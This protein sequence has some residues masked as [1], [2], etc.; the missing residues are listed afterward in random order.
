M[1]DWTKETWGAVLTVLLIVDYRYRNNATRRP[2]GRCD[3][4]RVKKQPGRLLRGWGG[5]SGKNISSLLPPR[6]D[7]KITEKT[8]ASHTR[9]ATTLQK[10]EVLVM[11]QSSST[12]KAPSTDKSTDEKNSGGSLRRPCQAAPAREGTPAPG[13]APA[14]HL[15]RSRSYSA[16]HSHAFTL[17]ALHYKH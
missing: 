5:F 3:L 8:H 16:D 12:E 6:G 11:S 13:P 4:A 10:Q 9:P 2:P 7:T 14:T 15:L 17:R 1:G